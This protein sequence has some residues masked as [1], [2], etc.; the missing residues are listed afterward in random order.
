MCNRC[1]NK[2]VAKKWAMWS[3]IVLTF[4]LFLFT[5]IFMYGKAMGV[6]ETHIENA[7]T[8]RGISEEYVDKDEFDTIKDMILYLYKKEGGN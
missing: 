1:D 7:P 4:L 8:Y 2:M 3:G 6:I 5:Q